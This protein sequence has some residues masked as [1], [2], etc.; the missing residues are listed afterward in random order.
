MTPA[1][2]KKVEEFRHEIEPNRVRY[3]QEDPSLL[4]V[5]VDGAPITIFKR[6]K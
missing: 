3:F 6:G 1:I 5:R 4:A 2:V